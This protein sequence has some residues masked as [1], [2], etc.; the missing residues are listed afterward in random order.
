MEI[1]TLT[2]VELEQVSGGGDIP[3][4]PIPGEMQNG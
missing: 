1:E 2:D 3:M 4:P